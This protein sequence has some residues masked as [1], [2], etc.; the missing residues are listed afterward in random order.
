MS[1]FFSVWRNVKSI[2]FQK[3]K[4]PKLC[5]P[6]LSPRYENSETQKHRPELPSVN[7]WRD[8]S[9]SINEA[10]N[11]FLKVQ[12]AIQK[13]TTCA[14]PWASTPVQRTEWDICI[15][16][17][18]GDPETLDPVTKALQRFFLTFA[19]FLKCCAKEKIPTHQPKKLQPWQSG[20][21][22]STSTGS[23][24]SIDA[25]Q[26]CHQ[27][28]LWIWRVTTSPESWYENQTSLFV[29]TQKRVNST[30][31]SFDWKSTLFFLHEEDLTDSLKIVHIEFKILSTL[32]SRTCILKQVM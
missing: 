20:C 12:H 11:Q 16:L 25:E 6:I 2:T 31:F 15:C 19:L 3:R 10:L 28:D 29:H 14:P 13:V 22:L 1:S 27:L 23:Y 8:F 32:V 17:S 30:Q 26:F 4:K 18:G 5:S 9:R 24:F 21:T 7:V